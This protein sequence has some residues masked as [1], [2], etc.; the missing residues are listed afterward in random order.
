MSIE[1]SDNMKISKEI[2]SKLNEHYHLVIRQLELFI[3]LDG[4][5]THFEMATI[6]Y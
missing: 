5:L 2:E 1:V 4:V 3:L 6:R